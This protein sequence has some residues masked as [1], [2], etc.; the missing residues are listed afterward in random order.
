MGRNE[1]NILTDDNSLAVY[2]IEL[3]SKYI[4][5]SQLDMYSRYR[6]TLGAE[7]LPDDLAPFTPNRRHASF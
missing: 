1:S 5:H 4:Y 2:D 3:G 7:L 6:G